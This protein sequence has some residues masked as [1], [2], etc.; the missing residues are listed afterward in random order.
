MRHQGFLNF[1]L[2][3]TEDQQFHKFIMLTMMLPFTHDS[4]IRWEEVF[5]GTDSDAL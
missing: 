1:L 5:V 3:V 4:A 2:F